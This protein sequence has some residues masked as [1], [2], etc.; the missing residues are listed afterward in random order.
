MQRT[1]A[2]RVEY[3][4]IDIGLAANRRRVAQIGSD[5]LDGLD[6]E[7]GER[8]F[9][10]GIG[11]RRRMHDLHRA[12]RRVPGAKVLRREIVAHRLLQIRI[13][14]IGTNR[15]CLAGIID[16][17]EQALAGQL[18]AAAHEPRELPVVDRDLVVCATLAG[19][20]QQ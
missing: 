20:A 15:A 12:Q 17:L 7:P 8:A 3:E 1:T 14:L 11:Q 2:P 4:R 18:V 6:N 10:Q 9:A 16:V 19:E 13:D 5:L